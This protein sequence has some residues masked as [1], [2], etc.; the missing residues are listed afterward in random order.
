MSATAIEPLLTAK[1]V[2]AMLGV[3][4]SWVYTQAR[5]GRI[6]TVRLGRYA[7]FRREAVEAWVSEL[8]TA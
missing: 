5:E 3:P 6:P 2:A 8:E 4:V 1:D 7:R